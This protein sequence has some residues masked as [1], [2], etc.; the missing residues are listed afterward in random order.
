MEDCLILVDLMDNPVGE[1]GKLEAHK[2]S[3]L[4]RA[5]SVFLYREDEMLI[6]KRAEGKYHSAGLWANTCCSHPRVGETLEK[7]VPR[8]LLE[9]A[10]I[11]YDMEDLVHLN[12]FVYREDFGELAEY[13]LDHVFVGCY[14][15]EYT[16]NPEEIGEMKWVKIDTLAEELRCYPQKFS[17]WFITAFPM[18]Y[19]YIKE[20]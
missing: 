7:A 19:Q 14:N 13:E 17:A 20:K 18:V 10:D 8:R 9:E 3:L 4:H 6:Q 1:A 11:R 16:P 2:N 15:G 12:S 5:F